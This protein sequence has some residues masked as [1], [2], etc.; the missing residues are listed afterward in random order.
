MDFSLAALL[1]IRTPEQGKLY[2]TPLY[3]SPEQI[4]GRYLDA[5]SDI[6]ALGMIL[7]RMVTGYHPYESARSLQQLLTYQLE[8]VLAEPRKCNPDVP[9][10]FSACIMKALEKDPRKRYYSCREFLDAMGDALPAAVQRERNPANQRWDTRVTV[11]LI[12]RIR[13]RTG[14]AWLPIRLKNLSV[15]GARAAAP[16]A[17]E[18]G[19]KLE[20]EFEIPEGGAYVSMSTT[21]TVLWR[22]AAYASADV[23]IGLNFTGFNDMDKRYVA[24]FIRN[25][26]L[27]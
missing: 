18:P 25:L 17:V 24:L 27:R 20:V 22:D 12:A 5:R 1:Q 21:A 13:L 6:Y 16:V 23:E 3:M 10:K 19:S 11:D 4:N 8:W 14:D 2:G 9:A 15:T 7:Y 26:L